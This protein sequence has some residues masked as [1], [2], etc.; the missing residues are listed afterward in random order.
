MMNI[1]LFVVF[2]C[3]V[4]VFNHAEKTYYDE[5]AM[6]RSGQIIYG[7]NTNGIHISRDGGKTWKVSSDCIAPSSLDVSSDGQYALAVF[8][9]SGP[10]GRAITTSDSGQ[11]WSKPTLPSRA[12]SFIDADVSG[13]G[14]VMII[15]EW[16]TGNGQNDIYASQDYG[17]N[18]QEVNRTDCINLYSVTM[19][20]AG[21][22]IFVGQSYGLLLQSKDYGVTF[23]PVT[24]VPYQGSY[25]KLSCDEKGS[26]ILASSSNG[27]S[28]ST[29]GGLN[30][31]GTTLPRNVNYRTAINGD[32]Q[33]QYAIG[34]RQMIYRSE[35]F[36]LTW[37]TAENSPM[38]NWASVDC[39]RSGQFAVA[40]S[41]ERGF[42]LTSDFGKTWTLANV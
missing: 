4:F 13:D 32:G 37:A 5:V 7:S 41:E 17:A 26:Y 12:K 1:S 22:R 2:V 39:D 30:F 18:F 23:N 33:Y 27:V 16:N 19:S 3:M 24:T 40:S 25:S 14:K 8:N 11:T 20:L 38:T 36:G 42:Y 10:C 35:D 15:V 6:D 31:N 21:D 9:P 34:S 28:I 29:N